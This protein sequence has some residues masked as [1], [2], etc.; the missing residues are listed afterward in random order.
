VD[1]HEILFELVQYQPVGM[2]DLVDLVLGEGVKYPDQRLPVLEAILDNAR[3]AWRVAEDRSGLVRRVAEPVAQSL[4]GAVAAAPPNAAEHLSAAWRHA[5]ARHP[6]TVEAYSEAVKAV[7]AAVLPVV[8]P[9]HPILSQAVTK[10]D[11]EKDNW[12]RVMVSHRRGED[13]IEP[14]IGMLRMLQNGHLGRHA[15]PGGPTPSP[16]PESARAAMQLAAPHLDANS[17]V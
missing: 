2:L 17:A 7:E 13:G 3:S 11:R 5:F 6:N 15:V 9:D 16:T 4:A 1:D 8:R 10:L 14:V 12:Q